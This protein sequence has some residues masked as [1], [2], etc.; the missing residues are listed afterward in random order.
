MKHNEEVFDE[1]KLASKSAYL[2]L[3]QIRNSV[4]HHTVT[5]PILLIRLS[6]RCLAT[7]MIAELWSA[8]PMKQR[9]VL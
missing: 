1:N 8:N 5:F 3:C 9:F 4:V 7:S 6:G 2:T